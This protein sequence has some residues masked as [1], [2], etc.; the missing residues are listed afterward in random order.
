MENSRLSKL[1][2]ELRNEIWALTIED[3][4]SLGIEHRDTAQPPMTR[5]CKQIRDKALLMF[6]AVNQFDMSFSICLDET[7][8]DT[9]FVKP[10]LSK[11]TAWLESVSA[12]CHSLVP[13]AP[14]DIDVECYR[15]LVSK[16]TL[17]NQAN[18]WSELARSPDAVGYKDAQLRVHVLLRD[19]YRDLVT[20]S[21]A[22]IPATEQAFLQVGLAVSVE[23]S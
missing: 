2:A 6:Y 15:R 20:F 16:V 17:G 1:S 14:I 22:I 10:M 12:Q 18:N 21:Y 13:L 9:P 19:E 5:A 7:L 23:V 11:F 3:P 4:C 8:D